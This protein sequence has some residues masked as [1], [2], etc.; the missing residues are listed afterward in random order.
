MPLLAKK[1]H[2]CS[3]LGFQGLN[4]VT[5]EK[6]RGSGQS[7]CKS[8]QANSSTTVTLSS[9]SLVTVSSVVTGF[10]SYSRPL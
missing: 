3:H 6:D 2:S 5:G 4:A 8:V 7:E 10:S 9:K 1:K